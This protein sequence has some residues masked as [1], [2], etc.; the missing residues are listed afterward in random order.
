MAL[1]VCP[2]AGM[3]KLPVLVV[4]LS[5]II[6]FAAAQHLFSTAATRH[7]RDPVTLT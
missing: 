7:R 3:Q 1:D 4:L 5:F 2:C 6:T